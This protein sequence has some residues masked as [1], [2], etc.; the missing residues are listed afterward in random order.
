MKFFRRKKHKQAVA[1]FADV[2]TRIR[3]FILDTQIPSGHDVADVLGCVPI[4]DEIAEREEQESDKRVARTNYLVTL[5][6]GYASLFAAGTVDFSN[7]DEEELPPE[8]AKIMGQLEI[9]TK[10]MLEDNLAHFT[11]GAITQMVDLKLLEVPR[12][13]K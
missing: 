10:A 11:L 5:I 9:A 6:Y 8:M 1:N 2:K 13:Y 7:L 3:E 4:S 12:K